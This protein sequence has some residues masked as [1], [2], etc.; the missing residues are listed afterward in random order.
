MLLFLYINFEFVV[1]RLFKVMVVSRKIM[2]LWN[3]VVYF[4]NFEVII[5]N[6]ELSI[7]L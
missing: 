5:N 3:I 2:I 6:F 1:G 4:D 7:L